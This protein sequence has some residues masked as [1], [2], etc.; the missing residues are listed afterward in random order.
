MNILFSIHE[1]ALNGAVIALL[2]QAR[3]LRD[4]GHGVHVITP[5][6]EGPAA[7]LRERFER[8]GIVLTQSAALDGFDVVIGCTIFA[9]DALHAALGRKPIIW[10]IH[11]GYAGLR[12][13]LSNPRSAELFAR[14]DGLVFPSRA[15]VETVYAPL[16]EGAAAGRIEIVPGIVEPPPPGARAEKA[17]GVI[18]ILCVGSVYPRKRQSDLIQA[19]AALRGSPIECVFVGHY[20]AIDEPGKSLADGHPSRFVFPGALMPEQVHELYR[21]ADIFCLPSGDECMPLAPVEA[22]W[23]DLPVL[24]ADLPTYRGVWR[25]GQNTLLHPPGD[26][27]L[28][29]WNIRMLVESPRLR[30]RLTQQARVTA[31]SFRASR[32][33]PLFEAALARA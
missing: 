17:D 32:A 6:L 27:E 1:L 10:W 19:V 11:E 18:R 9:A 20:F 25:H 22:A 13:I 30:N 5:A 29:A 14:A 15:V 8:A 12:H 23:H 24:M 26:V 2:E 3:R 33:V 4:R 31:G 28:L 7:A 16:L 21:S